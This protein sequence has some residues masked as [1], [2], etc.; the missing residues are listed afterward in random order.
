MQIQ[1]ANKSEGKK[2]WRKGGK[3][4][5]KEEENILRRRRVEGLVLCVFKTYYEVGDQGNKHRQ[6]E[7][8]IDRTVQLLNP[9]IDP[10]VY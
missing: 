6:K 8:T 5:G 2:K 1:R 7:E 10:H 3:E 9:E 4:G